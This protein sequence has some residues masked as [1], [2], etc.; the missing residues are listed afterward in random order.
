M[1][2]TLCALRAAGIQGSSAWAPW[3]FSRAQ[4]HAE[5]LLDVVADEQ[6]GEQALAPKKKDQAFV[7]K[8]LPLYLLLQLRAA[9]S[10]EKEVPAARP[11][12]QRASAWAPAGPPRRGRWAR[13]CR[14][15]EHLEELRQREVPAC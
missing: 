10:L 8:V 9:P 1:A 7:D 5:P 3:Q 13:R 12:R 2:V 15:R 14:L 11:A 6:P 4:L